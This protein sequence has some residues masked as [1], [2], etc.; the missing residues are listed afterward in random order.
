MAA[1]MLKVPEDTARVLREIPVPGQ[2]ETS[3]QHITVIYLG[4]DI[5]IERISAMVP[6]LYGVTSKTLPFAVKTDHVSNFPGG[7]DGV[8]VIAQIKSPELHDFR[9]ALCDALDEA[10]L[11]W[12]KK[13]P[14]YS[15][16]TTLAYDPNPETTVDLDIP[17]LIWGVS[18]LVLWGSNRG[19]GRLVVKFPLSLTLGKAAATSSQESAL[20]RASVQVA[21]WAQRDRFA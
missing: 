16:H 8:P 19:E 18:E 4:K 12:D 14:D 6:V 11:P 5:P 3:E 21:A 9:Q 1:L 2:K 10:E 13:F 17:E 20:Y 7:D 15:P